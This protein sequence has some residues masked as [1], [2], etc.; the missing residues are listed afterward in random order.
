M[1]TVCKIVIFHTQ[2]LYSW[3]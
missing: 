1:L 3:L 2:I